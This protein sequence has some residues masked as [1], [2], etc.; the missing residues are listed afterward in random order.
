[1]VLKN[2]IF[3]FF[4]SDLQVNNCGLQLVIQTSSI[5][6]K[7]KPVILTFSVTVIVISAVILCSQICRLSDK[8]YLFSSNMLVF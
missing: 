4:S 8:N 7:S 1:M 6:D 3:C 2:V 5:A